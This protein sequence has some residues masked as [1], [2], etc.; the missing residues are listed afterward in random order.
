MKQYNRL[1][2]NGCSFVAGGHLGDFGEN[3][4]NTHFLMSLQ[5]K[6]NC[7]YKSDFWSNKSYNIAKAGKSND[8]I[9]RTMTYWLF[10][11]QDKIKD[12]LF[13]IGL[14]ELSRIEYY[15]VVGTRY[16]TYYPE[17][18]NDDYWKRLFSSSLTGEEGLKFIEKLY[19]YTFDNTIRANELYLQLSLIQDY[20]C[21]R[22]GELVLFSSLCTE[23]NHKE[24]FNYFEFQNHDTWNDWAIDKSGG[25]T[26]PDKISM[27][28]Y[29]SPTAHPGPKANKELSNMLYNYI[30]NGFK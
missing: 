2:V 3:Y 16:R 5:D 6:L 30:K 20:I 9:C 10:N 23:F 14:T 4:G 26:R 29:L 19:K 7:K 18:E 12:T 22:G 1:L 28:Q 21:H 8:Y 24:K 25:N 13:I 27:D 11:N 17:V 15:D